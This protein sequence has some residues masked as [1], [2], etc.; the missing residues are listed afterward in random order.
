MESAVCRPGLRHNP[1][2][3]TSIWAQEPPVARFEGRQPHQ[4]EM[5]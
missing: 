1:A 2:L 4:E 3:Q 5:G